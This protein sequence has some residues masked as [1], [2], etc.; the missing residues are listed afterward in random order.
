MSRTG[1]FFSTPAQGMA[2]SSRLTLQPV[3]IEPDPQ[4]VRT[5]AFFGLDY[6]LGM[7]ALFQRNGMKA[8]LVCAACFVC[9]ASQTVADEAG[10]VEDPKPLAVKSSGQSSTSENGPPVEID[11]VGEKKVRHQ[12]SQSK[13]SDRPCLPTRNVGIA[14]KAEYYYSSC[15]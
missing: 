15:R 9:L 1:I 13:L 10:S 12:T 11:W 8:L 3:G 7:D 14:E 5:L 6:F 4:T 2:N